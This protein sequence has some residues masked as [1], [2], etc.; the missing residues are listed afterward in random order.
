[1]GAAGGVMMFLLLLAGMV[2]VG[3]YVFAYA[4]HILL[5]VSEKGICSSVNWCIIIGSGDLPFCSECQ[6]PFSAIRA[7]TSFRTR[8]AGRGL[9]TGKRMVPFDVL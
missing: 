5:T 8:A 6:P 3:S 9:S 2:I 7:L 1:M 4:A